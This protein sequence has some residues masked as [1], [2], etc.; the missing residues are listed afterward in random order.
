MD[1][2]IGNIGYCA[3]KKTWKKQRSYR[4]NVKMA[5]IGST[6]IRRESQ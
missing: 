1:A 5:L 2:V 3:R 6:I 4:N